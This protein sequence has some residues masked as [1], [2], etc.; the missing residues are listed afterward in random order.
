MNGRTALAEHGYLVVRGLIEQAVAD[1]CLQQIR[2]VFD[3]QLKHLGATPAPDLF[4]AA[5]VLHHADIDRFKKTMASLWRLQAIG[6]LFNTAPIQKFLRAVLGFGP[7]FVPGGQTVHLQSA[8]LKIPGG[9]FGLPAHQD[10]PSVQGSMDGI[11]VWVPLCAVDA[12]AY[13]LE[14]VPGSHRRGLVAPAHDRL[15]GI[16]NVDNFADLDFQ[17]LCVVPGDVV[18]FSNFLVHRS[19][20]TGRPNFVRVACSTRFDNGDEPSFV[21]RAYPSAYTRGVHRQLMDFP[22]VEA[23]NRQLAIASEPAPPAPP[24][25]ASAAT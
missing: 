12:D 1:D 24:P 11:G 25:N 17:S 18:F 10:W 3:N 2:N 6:A 19:G 14:V 21:A 9:Y 20:L 7:I 15:D 5:L 4:S 13:P 22:D 16:W 23:V 8:E